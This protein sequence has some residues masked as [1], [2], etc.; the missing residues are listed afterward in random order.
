M[1]KKEKALETMSST[2]ERVFWPVRRS[3]NPPTFGA[4]GRSVVGK[5][6]RSRPEPFPAIRAQDFEINVF[7]GYFQSHGGVIAAATRGGSR[8]ALSGGA[9]PGAG[10]AVLLDETLDQRKAGLNPRRDFYG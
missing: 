5:F 8:S 4:T 6:E 1:K 7:D 3:G 2:L 10:E 9:I